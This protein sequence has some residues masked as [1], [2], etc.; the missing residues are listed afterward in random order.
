MRVTIQMQDRNVVLGP[1]DLFV[2][3]RGTEHCPR[4]DVETTVLPLEPS[5]VI[6]T[7]GAGGEFTAEAGTLS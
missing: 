1:R 2:L 5:T 3:P 6:T 7:G 4:A